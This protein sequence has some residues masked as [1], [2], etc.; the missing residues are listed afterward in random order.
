M[1]GVT[2]WIRNAIHFYTESSTRICDHVEER[3]V[4]ELS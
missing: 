4:G 2:K 3:G 1:N